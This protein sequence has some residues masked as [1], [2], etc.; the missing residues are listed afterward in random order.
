MFSWGATRKALEVGLKAKVIQRFSNLAGFSSA[1]Q[2]QS[3]S[4][5]WRIAAIFPS[6]KTMIHL[7]SWSLNSFQYGRSFWSLAVRARKNMKSKVPQA[8]CWSHGSA[9]LFCV[10]HDFAVIGEPE[11]QATGSGADIAIG[12]LYS[13]KGDDP[14]QRIKTALK[15]AIEH[16]M[17]CG[18]STLIKKT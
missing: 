1:V 3:E 9:N 8:V 7:N 5:T 16:D 6:L 15:A 12:S 13:T 14:K 4:A 17:G 11:Y 18:G 10:A 2:E